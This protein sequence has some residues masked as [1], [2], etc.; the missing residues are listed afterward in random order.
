MPKRRKKKLVRVI[1]QS[2]GPLP[3]RLAGRFIGCRLI[4]SD[5]S[6]KRHGGLAV[7][8]FGDP[9]SPPLVATR[10][11][12]LAGS[13][14]LELAAALFGLEEAQRQFPGEP[15]ALFS[16]NQDAVTRLGRARAEGLAHDPA[17]ARML[18]ERGLAGVPDCVAV[19]WV[20]GHAACRGNALADQ[21]ARAAA[22]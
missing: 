8:L 13:N 3:L 20:Q 17:L 12:A 11:V 22:G 10:S 14:E 1:H 5:A 15:A 21:H 6:R 19:C 16:D 2:A 18:A 4:F 9:V 7:V